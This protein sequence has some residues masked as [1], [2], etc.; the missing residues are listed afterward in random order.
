LSYFDA[1]GPAN[2]QQHVGGPKHV[3]LEQVPSVPFRFSSLLFRF[4]FSSFS[5]VSVPFHFRFSSLSFRFPFISLPFHFASVPFFS[6]PGRFLFASVRFHFVSFSFRF[7]SLSLRCGL[8]HLDAIGPA[9]EQK[10]VGGP[11]QVRL[12]QV[13][14]WAAFRAVDVRDALVRRTVVNLCPTS[15]T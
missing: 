13:R 8:S 15:Q 12:E 4:R 6:P 10:C 3:R 9:N 7:A 1:I 5:F 11:E 14:A 2:E